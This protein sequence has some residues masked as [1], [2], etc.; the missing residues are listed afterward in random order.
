[1]ILNRPGSRAPASCV[2]SY[3]Y[4]RIHANVRLHESVAALLE[5]LVDRK[6]MI[7]RLCNVGLAS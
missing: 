2:N 3:K 1:M 7:K 4:G 6:K 5:Y